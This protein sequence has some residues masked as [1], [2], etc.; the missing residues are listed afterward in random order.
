L[1]T[2]VNHFTG[3]RMGSWQVVV[4]MQAVG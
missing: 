4:V 1:L 2:C 3:I